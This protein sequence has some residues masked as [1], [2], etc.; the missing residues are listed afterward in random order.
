MDHW[1]GQQGAQ[2]VA[3]ATAATANITG[4]YPANEAH[5]ARQAP[6]TTSKDTCCEL[7]FSITI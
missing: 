2:A 7:W 4:G 6:S 5:I 1:K 3:A